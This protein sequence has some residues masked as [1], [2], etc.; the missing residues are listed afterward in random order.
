MRLKAPRIEPVPAENW[1]EEQ[2]EIVAPMQARGRIINIFRTM[3]AHP[4]AA[5]AFLTWGGYILSRKA[6]LSPRER[7]IVILRTGFLCKSGYEWTQHV[8]IGRKAGLTDA[9][10][11]RIKLGADVPAWS[12]PDMALL[13]A[14]DD[15][16]RE[17]FI[18]GP[19]WAELTKYFNEQQRMDVVFTVGQYTQVSMLLNTFGVQLD[20]GQWLDP[21]LKGF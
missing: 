12:A 10:I 6:T 14:A 20:E 15:L 2:R 7:E 18:T 1:T 13:R 19:V 16:H 8:P 21:D 5:K 4:A 9:E 11:A 17:Y 3:L